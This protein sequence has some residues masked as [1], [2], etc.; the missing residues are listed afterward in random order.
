MHQLLP[1]NSVMLKRILLLACMNR[2]SFGFVK[3][4]ALLLREFATTDVIR[5]MAAS[6]VEAF[7]EKTLEVEKSKFIARIYPAS[8]VDDALNRVQES[9]VL[10]PKASHVC[11]A[12]RGTG[13]QPATRYS[14]DGEPASTAG[15]PIMNALETENVC[16][17]VCIVVRYFGG[18]KLGTGGLVRSYGLAARDALAIATKIPIIESCQ[19]VVKFPSY[20]DLSK[21]YNVL[22]KFAATKLREDFFDDGSCSMTVQVAMNEKMPFLLQLREQSAGRVVFTE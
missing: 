18:I 3:S 7:V 6:V 13:Q 4:S 8:S 9:R 16:N 11:W 22:G 20:Q 14:D 15:R 1:Y 2:V 21:C 19:V 12:W 5:N 17:T 10:D